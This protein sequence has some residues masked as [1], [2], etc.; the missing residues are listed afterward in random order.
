MDVIKIEEVWYT[1]SEIIAYK[2]KADE[3]DSVAALN[4]R[5]KERVA[6][7]DESLIKV[8]EWFHNLDWDDSDTATV[9][10][11]AL[12][13]LKGAKNN[14]SGVEKVLID[15]KKGIVKL[16]PA[17]A[18]IELF[19][20]ESQEIVNIHFTD[21][22]KVSEI[23]ELLNQFKTKY[24]DNG[25]IPAFQNQLLLGLYLILLPTTEA[26]PFVDCDVI[27]K[28]RSRFCGSIAPESNSKT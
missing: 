13:L 15:D 10:I 22:Y 7:R 23:L 20:N 5:L 28:V 14:G 17:K 3:H 27:D 12:S 26:A 6:E 1:A 8:R 19:N 24:F 9:T 11:M 21:S 4:S 25:Q 16:K 2:K 18:I